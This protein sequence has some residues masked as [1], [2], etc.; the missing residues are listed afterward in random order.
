MAEFFN[1]KEELLEVQ[2]TDYGKYMLS[3]GKLKPSYYAFYDDEILYNT[4]YAPSQSSGDRVVEAQ[5]DTD[6][7]IRFET[8]NL[9]VVPT[10]TGAETRVTRFIS[11]ITSSLGTH[12]SD[13]AD[14]VESF[15]QQ[16]FIEKVNFSSYPIGTAS[17]SSDKAASWTVNALSNTIESATEFIITN[18]SSSFADI[19]NGVITR[20]PQLNIEVDYQMFYRDGELGRDAIS[21]YFANVPGNLYLALREDYVILDIV[22]ENTNDETHNFEIEVFYQC[23]ATGSEPIPSTLE[24]MEFMTTN[25]AYPSLGEPVSLLSI[26]K[27]LGNQETNIGNVEYYFDV[28]SDEELP[29]DMIAQNAVDAAVVDGPRAYSRNLYITEDEDPC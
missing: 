17:P 12:N 23:D 18:P 10:R 22:E 4:E 5:N 19:N 13:P 29:L 3:L 11:S 26:P 15:Q 16:S 24:A 21:G 2:L 27:P 20:I 1:K 8:P 7:R 14:A 25:A 9:K 6:R 28:Y